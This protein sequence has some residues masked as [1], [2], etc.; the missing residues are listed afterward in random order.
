M[1][2]KRYTGNIITDTPTD[3][4]GDAAGGVWSLAEINEYKSANAWPTLPEAPTIGTATA[5][6]DGVAT[7]T[8]TAPEL[9][10]GTLSQYTAT[11]SPSSITGTGT[12]SPITVSGLTNG[13]SYTFTVSATTGA[14][15][16]PE[17]ASSN[18]VSPEA[19]ARGVIAGGYAGG[20]I[21][22]NTNVIEYVTINTSGN[23]TDFGDLTAANQISSGGMSSSTR[24]L[25]AHSSMSNIVDYI[26]IAST[27]NA[28]DFGDQSYA[29]QYAAAVSNSTRG[30]I[31]GGNRS[32]DSYM[33]EIDYFTISS[34][35][36]YT[37]FGN[38]FE[39]RY[40]L[41]SCSST[42]RAIFGGG[43]NG[44]SSVTIDYVTI[45]STGNAFDFGDLYNDG[46]GFPYGSKTYLGACSSNTRGVFMGGASGTSGR[47]MGYVTISTLGNGSDFGDLVDGTQ[48]NTG[49]SNKVTG[50]SIGGYVGGVHSDQIQQITIASTGNATDFGD[51][52]TPTY[53][54]GS[55]SDSH[56]GLSQ[57]E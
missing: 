40:G 8:F 57:G 11:S 23:A 9:Y 53:F 56:G 44:S 14:G 16:G 17:S 30:L 43:Y 25:F 31:A 49:T 48:Y 22:A 36:N 4:T 10:G 12:T 46:T 3:P 42:T 28:S 29:K 45:S 35:G 27:G 26:T 32:G 47:T 39:Q 24:G 54:A 1:T 38:L 6:I 2:S 7:V 37:D 20:S 5:G 55:L 34:T 13:T 18:S 51:L 50:L 21:N 15:T 41:A 33:D 19:G 52:T